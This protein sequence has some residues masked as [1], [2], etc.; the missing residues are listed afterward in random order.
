MRWIGLTTQTSQTP[1]AT[2]ALI[3]LQPL[4]DIAEAF[5]SVASPCQDEPTPLLF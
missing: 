4:D 5:Q 1:Y 2:G 3:M